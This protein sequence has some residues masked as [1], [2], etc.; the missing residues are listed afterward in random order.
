MSLMWRTIATTF[1]TVFLAELGDKTQLAT[2]GLSASSERKLPVFIGSATALVATSLIAVLAGG[3]L[4]RHVSPTHLQRAA[5][6]LFMVL[7]VWTL[8]TAGA[9]R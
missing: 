7:G 5:G 2:L 3:W 4:A 8:V 9:A 6:T 1:V